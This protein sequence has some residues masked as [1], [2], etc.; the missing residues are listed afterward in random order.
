M[1][2]SQNIRYVAQY[3]FVYILVRRGWGVVQSP[4]SKSAN[5]PHPFPGTDIH[6]FQ[7]VVRLL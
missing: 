1:F 4:D 5:D 6:N 3:V 7:K 2:Y